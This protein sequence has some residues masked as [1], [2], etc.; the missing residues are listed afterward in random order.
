MALRWATASAEVNRKPDEGVTG[1]VHFFSSVGK[2]DEGVTGS[3]HLLV[4]E[5]MFPQPAPVFSVA[6]ARVAAGLPAGEAGLRP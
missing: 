1:S 6:P 2:P 4:G 3:V 5:T